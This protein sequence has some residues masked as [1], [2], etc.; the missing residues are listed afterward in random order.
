V[1]HASDPGRALELCAESSRTTHAAPTAVDACRYFWALLLG[2]LGG[3]GKEEILSPHYTP[4]PGYWE[5]RP[6]AAEIAEIAEGSFRAKQP[7]AIRGTGFVVESLEAALWAF[8]STSDFRSGCLAA[9]NLGDDAD[10]TAAVFG[11]IG[12]AF[13]GESAIPS[14]W[15]QRLALWETIDRYADRLAAGLNGV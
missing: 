9:A 7:P 1:F 3:V 4:V 5:R 2:A 10:T 13:Y 12:G 11:Q 14:E 15:R 6:L 8:A